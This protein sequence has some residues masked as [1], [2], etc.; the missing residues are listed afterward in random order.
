MNSPTS[1]LGIG[2][3][4]ARTAVG[5]SWPSA[6][7]AVRAGITRLQGHPYMVNRDGEPYVVAAVPGLEPTS[8]FERCFELLRSLVEDASPIADSVRGRLAVWLSLPEGF[9]ASSALFESAIRQGLGRE[10]VSVHIVARGHAS[11]LLAMHQCKTKIEAGN[12][13][14][15]VL[16][17]VDSYIDPDILE[18]LDESGELMSDGN[19]FGFPPG[20][21]AAG[22]IVAADSTL[23]N[24]GLPVLGRVV[25]VGLGVEAEPMGSE[26]VSTGVGLAAA[27]DGATKQFSAKHA[28]GRIYSD[29]N[30]QRYR[31]SDYVWATQRVR[32]VFTD[33][34]DFVTPAEA[35]G[36][37]GAATSLLLV[38][39]SLALAPH[40]RQRSPATLVYA[41]SMGS[42]RAAITL[43]HDTIA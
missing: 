37:V 35:W 8:R 36:D 38:G 9:D 6:S 14:A 2:A 3:A 4:F 39:L 32:P 26:G 5:L 11:G 10:G 25:D 7:A 19:K 17:G 43:H 31:D 13:D 41:C 40:L 16:L 28:V 23:R 29:Q 30:G 42:D 20:E 21:A 15:A 24:A 33:T 27:I 12:L 34:S 1:R 18:A 22:L